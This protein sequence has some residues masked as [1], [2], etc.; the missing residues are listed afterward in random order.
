MLELTQNN[1]VICLE[2]S[3]TSNPL[4]HK[5]SDF[6]CNCKIYFHNNCWSSYLNRD[7]RCPYCRIIRPVPYN[8]PDQEH[9]PDPSFLYRLVRKYNIFLLFAQI[10]IAPC[11][12]LYTIGL[13]QLNPSDGHF[14]DII[15][16]SST[17]FLDFI[18]CLI[19]DCNTALLL[20]SN[21]KKLFLFFNIYKFLMC[22]VSVSMLCIG[23][24]NKYEYI[25]YGTI[26][27]ITSYCLLLLIF[28][29]TY[30]FTN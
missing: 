1:C 4:I 29:L 18:I 6:G 28:I 25:I 3:N 7:N 19:T 24:L 11:C 9:Q 14:L 16:I 30:I 27:Y 22:L 17:S 23:D 15:V 2:N 26:F 12:V 20:N 21:F 10:L 8:R 5:S 13:T